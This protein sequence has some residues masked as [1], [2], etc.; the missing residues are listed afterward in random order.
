MMVSSPSLKL[1]VI[2]LV[3]P[4]SFFASLAAPWRRHIGQAG[5][6]IAHVDAHRI[7]VGEVKCHTG[8]RFAIGI[9]FFHFADSDACAKLLGTFLG[10]IFSEHIGGLTAAKCRHLLHHRAHLRAEN[11]LLDDGS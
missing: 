4:A 8:S 2:G 7:D 11:R 6:A 9:D 1:K 5:S 10:S 3:S